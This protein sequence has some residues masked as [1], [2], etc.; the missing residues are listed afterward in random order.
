MQINITSVTVNQ[1]EVIFEGL[2]LDSVM[3]ANS[4]DVDF[5]TP[6]VQFRFDMENRY[7]RALLTKICIRQFCCKNE[8]TFA[9]KILA[10][11]NQIL[12]LPEKNLILE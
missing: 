3:E 10:L 6:E 9:R 12:F 5:D 2:N 4:L 7:D 11:N 8:P 1:M